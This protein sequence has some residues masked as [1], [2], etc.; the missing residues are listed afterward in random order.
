MRD[1]GQMAVCVCVCVCVRACSTVRRLTR[2]GESVGLHWGLVCETASQP[3]T[4]PRPLHQNCAVRKAI[5]IYNKLNWEPW[6]GTPVR[7]VL[8]V[9]GFAV[10]QEA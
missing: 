6:P 5:M 8:T 9:A 2:W 10:G 4:P 1:D 7:S 3:T